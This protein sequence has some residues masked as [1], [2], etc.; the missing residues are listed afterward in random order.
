MGRAVSGSE[1]ERIKGA[2]KTL[3]EISAAGAVARSGVSACA[4]RDVFASSVELHDGRIQSSRA[5]K[6]QRKGSSSLKCEKCQKQGLAL[7]RRALVLVRLAEW[8]VPWVAGE[9]WQTGLRRHRLW[10]G[11]AGSVGG[12]EPGQSC[13]R[14]GGGADSGDL[15]VLR[16][17][18]SFY[19]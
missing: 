14:P 15:C 3:P 6:L 11:G 12:Q 2:F 8:R 19:G 10:E 9:R 5:L 17:G 1:G 16:R 13:R 4:R 7:P 18:W